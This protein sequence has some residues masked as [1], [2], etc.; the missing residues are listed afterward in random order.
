MSFYTALASTAARLLNDK[1][2]TVTF[3]R[4]TGGTFDPILGQTSGA[5][6]T[7]FTGKAAAF[8]YNNAEID[9]TVIRSG[10]VRLV[11][12]TTTTVPATDDLCTVNSVQY[13]VM[14]VEPIAP[15]GTTVINKVQL[16]K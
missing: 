14:N 1:G 4:Q 3:S 16:R 13:R 12:E 11:V 6:T 10:D 2:Q 5:S 9:G 15:A 8:G 7:T